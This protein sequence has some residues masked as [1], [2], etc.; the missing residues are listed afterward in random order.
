[1]TKE[2]ILSLGSGESTDR[3]IADNLMG[4]V[5]KPYS[6]DMNA[7][8]EVI[9]WCRKNPPN[10]Y[11]HRGEYLF[12]MGERIQ[13]TGWYAIWSTGYAESSSDR[14][15]LAVAMTLPHAV[16]LTALQRFFL[17]GVCKSKL[18]RTAIAGMKEG[19]DI[20]LLVA[21]CVMGWNSLPVEFKPSTNISDAWAAV[22]QLTEKGY[23]LRLN[24]G[25]SLSG[26]FAW[27]A[28]YD[29]PSGVASD[30]AFFEDSVALAICKASLLAYSEGSK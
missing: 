17:G 22:S 7:A 23:R 8:Y 15:H 19:K 14:M 25:R 4:G 26:A 3:L 2:E 20:D 16:C 10:P 30:W 13:N 24:N 5:L 11:E 1:M 29:S 21:T 28:S 18:T 9:E 27:I 12:E 6:T